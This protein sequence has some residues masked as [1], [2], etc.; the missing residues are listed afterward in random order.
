MS[1]RANS[2]SNRGNNNHGLLGMPDDVDLVN[3]IRKPSLF[4]PKTWQRFIV[5]DLGFRQEKVDLLVETHYIRCCSEFF[6]ALAPDKE[7]GLHQHKFFPKNPQISNNTKPLSE[8]TELEK[9]LFEDN[10]ICKVCDQPS[11]KHVTYTVCKICC[12]E[13]KLEEMF[14]LL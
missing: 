2:I 13:Y 7:N 5:D 10:D 11:K 4:A 14:T 8:M 12:E 3:I 1:R 6:D 9:K